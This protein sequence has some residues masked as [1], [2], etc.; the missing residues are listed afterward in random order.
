LFIKPCKENSGCVVAKFENNI[1]NVSATNTSTVPSFCA[2][3]QSCP[4]HFHFITFARYLT[5]QAVDEFGDFKIGGQVIRTLKY[6][7]D[8]VVLVKEGMV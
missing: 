2:A 1:S 7:G 3:T 4:F 5:K 8:S 6:A